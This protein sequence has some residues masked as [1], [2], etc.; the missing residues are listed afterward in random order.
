MIKIRICPN[1][2]NF[3]K[4]NQLNFYGFNWFTYGSPYGNRTRDTAVKGRCLNRLTKGPYS[5]SGRKI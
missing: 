4:K 5:G 1:F 3:N 2:F